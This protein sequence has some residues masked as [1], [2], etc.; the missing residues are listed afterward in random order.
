MSTPTERPRPHTRPRRPVAPPRHLEGQGPVPHLRHATDG[1][2]GPGPTG[3][4]PTH[5]R[6]GPAEDGLGGPNRRPG[7]PDDPGRE[8]RP[9]VGVAPL[10]EGP[11]APK[12]GHGGTPGGSRI[13][14][15]RQRSPPGPPEPGADRGLPAGVDG[16]ERVETPAGLEVVHGVKDEVP[17]AE[18]VVVDRPS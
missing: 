14:V 18:E 13:P 7:T 4:Q 9:G 2:V 5:G 15:G 10:P 3:R 11:A 17:S 12:P 1:R 16:P 8:G 6:K